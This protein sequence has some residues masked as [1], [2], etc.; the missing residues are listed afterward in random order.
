[1]E[2]LAVMFSNTTQ[3]RQMGKWCFKKYMEF[4]HL[5]QCYFAKEKFL[6]NK[7]IIFVKQNSF[8]LKQEFECSL[9]FP[10]SNL[11]YTIESYVLLTLQKWKVYNTRSLSIIILVFKKSVKREYLQLIYIM[12]VFLRE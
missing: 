2:N 7:N 6:F 5:K 1:M 11:Q 4:F 12:H 3:H 8:F 9:S 10:P